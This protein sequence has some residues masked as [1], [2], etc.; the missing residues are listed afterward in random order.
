MRFLRT[1]S[2]RRLL[3]VLT[4][5]LIVVVG[6][7]AI[8]VAAAGNGPVPKRRSLAS[9]IHRALEAKPVKGLSATIAFTNNLIGS[10]DV[11][12]SDPLLT[13]AS[14]RLWA[15][16]G[17][18]RLE[19]QS[20]NGDAQIVFDHGSFWAY[21]PVMNVVYRGRLPAGA[22]ASSR[23]GRGSAA[24]ARSSARSGI[25]SIAQI[26]KAI[27]HL[28]RSVGISGAVPTDV[29]GAAAYRV[30]ISPKTGGGLIGDLKLA[31]DAT[32]GVPLDFAI[33]ARG[34]S[35]PVLELQASGISYGPV[36][37]SVFSIRPPSGARVVDVAIPRAS[38]RTSSSAHGTHHANL[39]T[40]VKAVQG[41]LAFKLAAPAMLAGRPRH[42][43]DLIGGHGALLVYGKGLGGIAVI[44]HP[45]RAGSAALPSSSPS[46][47][48]AGLTLPTANINGV[49]AQ[50][51]PTPL[52]TL[53]QFSRGGVSYLIVGSVTAGTADA[54]ARGL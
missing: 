32:H 43:V 38:H 53:V 29:G 22:I 28:A 24:A 14:G 18:I 48:T 16:D 15:G 52:G 31:W 27:E 13:G 47:D 39:V 19:L 42:S 45:A 54:A 34:D 10:S 35:T 17:R 36:P 5:L 20:T 7:S 21:D 46:A 9:A 51:L 8:A 41:H 30:A 1:V 3:A 4:G 49:R 12:G 44:E 33:Y 23:A 6:G 25:P 11:Q 2:T 50:Q 26:Q 37:A 40:G